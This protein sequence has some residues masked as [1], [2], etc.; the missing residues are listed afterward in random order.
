VIWSSP[1][2]VARTARIDGSAN[3]VLRS[4]ARSRGLLALRVL[5]NSTGSTPTTVRS[6]RSA[7][8]WIA[9]NTAGTAHDGD[10]TATRSPG[11]SDLGRTK[12][13]MRQ[14]SMA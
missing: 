10:K 3:A 11:R 13:S 9:G 7:C 5:G 14:S 12:R 2:I 4:S 1:P 8:S 6:R